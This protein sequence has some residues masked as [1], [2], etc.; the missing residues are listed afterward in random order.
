ML[1]NEVHT[2]RREHCQRGQLSEVLLVELRS[3]V[4][5]RLHLS[6]YL[7]SKPLVAKSSQKCESFKSTSLFPLRFEENVTHH[8]NMMA[9]VQAMNDISFIYK[10][11]IDRCALKSIKNTDTEYQIKTTLATEL[12]LRQKRKKQKNKN[13][14]RGRRPSAYLARL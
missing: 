10:Y 9:K 8:V 11:R 4:H 14:L 13:R 1:S 12:S 5:Q 2:S 6:R 3:L 7:H